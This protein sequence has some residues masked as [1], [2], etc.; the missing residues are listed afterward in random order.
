MR[1]EAQ[2]I[3]VRDTLHRSYSIEAQVA[4]HDDGTPVGLAVH[5]TY[6]L[7]PGEITPHAG[8]YT[9]T[10]L[11]SGVRL[12]DNY[13]VSEGIACRWLDLIALLIDWTQP[14]AVLRANET[15]RLQVRFA[16]VH[17]FWEDDATPAL[18]MAEAAALDLRT[19][20][21]PFTLLSLTAF[22]DWVSDAMEGEEFTEAAT[23]A[24][25]TLLALH[26]ELARVARTSS[27][28]VS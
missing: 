7:G 21:T 11:A 14:R 2:T 15:L 17:A 23:P 19:R 26:A 9:L 28:I 13:V 22:L 20:S 4:L 5:L 6:R 8:E 18:F 24:L 10:H 16:R 25:E 1:F 3:T 12:L 27:P